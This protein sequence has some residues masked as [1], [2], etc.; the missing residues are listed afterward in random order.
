M[1]FQRLFFNDVYFFSQS[2]LL[3]RSNLQHLYKAAVCFLYS[4]F[5]RLAK[6]K[7]FLVLCF[8]AQQCLRA[9]S[10]VSSNML[11]QSIFSNIGWLDFVWRGLFGTE[12]SGKSVN[13]PDN[14][15]VTSFPSTHFLFLP[16]CL[17]A[18][19]GWQPAS[20]MIP[21]KPHLFVFTYMYK[22]G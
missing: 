9:C 22:A 2:A 3:K 8:R 1:N 12:H 4:A 14:C 20:K 7:C 18:H 16:L 17:S 10:S 11:R 21:T 15:L 13:V 6:V 5:L 19:S